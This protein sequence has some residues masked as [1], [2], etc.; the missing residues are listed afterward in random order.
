MRGKSTHYSLT[1]QLRDYVGYL[2]A[3]NVIFVF[4]FLEEIFKV[5]IL[6]YAHSVV[7]TIEFVLPSKVLGKTKIDSVRNSPTLESHVFFE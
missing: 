6:I 3:K 7:I 1:F 5:S 4:N 2:L